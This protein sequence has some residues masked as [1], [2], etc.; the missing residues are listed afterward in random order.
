MSSFVEN[1]SRHRLRCAVV[2]KRSAWCRSLNAK[3]STIAIQSQPAQFC[4]P[5]LRQHQGPKDG[6]DSPHLSQTFS[7]DCC[8]A[9]ALR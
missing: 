7:S 1:L 2:L 4:V 6:T 8:R 3:L 5:H 9:S